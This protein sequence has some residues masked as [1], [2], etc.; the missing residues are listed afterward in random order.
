MHHPKGADVVPYSCHEKCAANAKRLFVIPIAPSPRCRGSGLTRIR[1][2]Q[3][4]RPT[5]V[6]QLLGSQYSFT[7][8]PT[9]TAWV[10]RVIVA[11][12][13]KMHDVM[14]VQFSEQVYLAH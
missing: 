12:S 1:E 14:G 7:Q 9:T 8:M 5:Q 11:M 13:G 4:R 3:Q 6:S 2:D 10:D